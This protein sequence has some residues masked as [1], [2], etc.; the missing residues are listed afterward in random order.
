MDKW[1]EIVRA[2]KIEAWIAGDNKKYNS[3][4]NIMLQLLAKDAE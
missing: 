4:D 3:Y 1:L 2:K